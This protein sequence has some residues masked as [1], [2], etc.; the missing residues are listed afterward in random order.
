[1]PFVISY[2]PIIPSIYSSISR[3][4]QFFVRDTHFCILFLLPYFLP[5]L[6]TGDRV[7]RNVNTEF[8]FHALFF[9]AD[10]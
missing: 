4:F 8:Y 1:V 10:T 7:S 9:M 6:L 3:A 5:S 2:L